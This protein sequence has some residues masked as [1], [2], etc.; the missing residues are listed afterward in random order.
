MVPLGPTGDASW[1]RRGEAALCAR[2]FPL[3]SSSIPLLSPTAF[4]NSGPGRASR[5]MAVDV[6][7]SRL[8]HFR[9]DI[10]GEKMKK[11]D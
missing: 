3:S 10:V 1:K 6:G 9:E 5:K 11:V 4:F 2:I 7:G 8:K